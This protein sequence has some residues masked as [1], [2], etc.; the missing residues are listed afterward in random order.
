[1]RGRSLPTNLPGLL[2]QLM[3][4]LTSFT[5]QE[6]EMAQFLKNRPMLQVSIHLCVHCAGSAARGVFPY[7]SLTPL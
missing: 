4:P 3:A 7:F 2:T 1:M 6:M 5:G